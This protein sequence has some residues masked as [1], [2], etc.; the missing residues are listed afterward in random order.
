MTLTNQSSFEMN[1]VN[2]FPALTAPFQLTFSNLF[3]AFAAEF[4]AILLTNLGKL[5][6]SK[7]IATLAGAFWLN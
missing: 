3:I 5:S 4:E 6:L 7:W 2:T 1:K